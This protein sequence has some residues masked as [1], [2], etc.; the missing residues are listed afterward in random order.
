MCIMAVWPES[1]ARV[2]PGGTLLTDWAG[3]GSAVRSALGFVVGSSSGA[4]V[5]SGG[6]L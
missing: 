6:T 1:A 5:P 3:V 2:P 4:I